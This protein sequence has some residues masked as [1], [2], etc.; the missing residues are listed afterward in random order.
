MV[1]SPKI[2]EFVLIGLAGAKSLMGIIGIMLHI[3]RKIDDTAYYRA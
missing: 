2:G 3:V 1:A